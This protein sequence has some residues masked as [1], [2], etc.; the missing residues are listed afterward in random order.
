QKISDEFTIEDAK[1]ITTLRSNMELSEDDF[2]NFIN[3]SK[4]IIRKNEY[5]KLYSKKSLQ[6]TL[7]KYL[8]QVI[9]MN[10]QRGRANYKIIRHDDHKLNIYSFLNLISNFR[11]Y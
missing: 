11:K 8:D 6:Q 2:L 9:Y 4:K 5:I 3:L 1:I 7:S 10:K